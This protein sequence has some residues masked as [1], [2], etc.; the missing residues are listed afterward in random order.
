MKEKLNRAAL[1]GDLFWMATGSSAD[2][3]NGP[4]CVVHRNVLGV[5]NFK[6]HS[7]SIITGTLLKY[8]KEELW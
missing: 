1:D 6:L 7:S 2:P 5:C 8:L 4:N 3:K